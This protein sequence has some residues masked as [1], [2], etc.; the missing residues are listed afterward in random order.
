MR[1]VKVLPMNAK[2]EWAPFVIQ[3]MIFS[4]TSCSLYPI[5]YEVAPALTNHMINIYLKD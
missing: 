5:D 2:D 1:H 3:A 4:I